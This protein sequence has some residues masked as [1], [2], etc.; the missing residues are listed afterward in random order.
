MKRLVKLFEEESG[1]LLPNNAM[2]FLE[3]HTQYVKWLE[4][5]LVKLLDNQLQPFTGDMHSFL[6][7]NALRS[8]NDKQKANLCFDL[9]CRNK[10]TDRI[11]K[12]IELFKL[13]RN[14][15]WN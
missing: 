4:L 15:N 11:D 10:N 14:N 6:L 5:N 8:L 7:N 1:L 9:Y 12:K 2:A 13:E 3:W